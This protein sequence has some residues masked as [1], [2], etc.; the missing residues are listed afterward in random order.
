MTHACIKEVIDYFL[1]RTKFPFV[2]IHKILQ[3]SL[4]LKSV[5]ISETSWD[6]QV[7]RYPE[8]TIIHLFSIY[9]D[10]LCPRECAEN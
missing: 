1:L 5:H 8:V 3:L 10:L 7:K 2:L 6:F 9:K 4:K